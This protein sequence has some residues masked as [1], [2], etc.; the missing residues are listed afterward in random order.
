MI[1]GQ[2]LVMSSLNFCMDLVFR[3]TLRLN[4]SRHTLRL[5]NIEEEIQATEESSDGTCFLLCENTDA[6]QSHLELLRRFKN[7]K[8]ERRSC[9]KFLSSLK[10]TLGIMSRAHVY[11]VYSSSPA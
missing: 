4:L 11:H 5:T 3:F 8:V 9:L 6:L 10:K 2:A 7:V 1:E